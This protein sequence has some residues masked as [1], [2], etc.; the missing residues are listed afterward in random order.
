MTH[1]DK[2]QSGR[3]NTYLFDKLNELTKDV[4]VR[5]NERTDDLQDIEE[6]FEELKNAQEG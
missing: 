1:S 5:K 6:T 3:T 2:C 4:A